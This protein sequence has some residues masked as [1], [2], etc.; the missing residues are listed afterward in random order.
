MRT[1]PSSQKKKQRYQE[2]KQKKE[3]LS[4]INQNSRKE[5]PQHHSLKNAEFDLLLR[6]KDSLKKL[7]MLR[8]SDN[9]ILSNFQKIL[10]KI[11]DKAH[12]QSRIQNFLSMAAHQVTTNQEYRQANQK[13]LDAKLNEF[14]ALADVNLS[15]PSQ[16][17]LREA[18]ILKS[19]NESLLKIEERSEKSEDL[20]DTYESQV[21]SES[22]GTPEYKKEASPPPSSSLSFSQLN[23][24]HIS[25]FKR[26]VGRLR[27]KM[28]KRSHA[29][30]LRAKLNS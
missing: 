5:H 10:K 8:S 30:Y 4:K 19:P 29:D 3:N 12:D 7:E 23:E 26:K 1:N 2:T 6:T 11:S 22:K 20:K 25:A 28:K 14:F 16:L 18:S 24:S 13:L 21:I 17:S 9:I 27:Q 15:I